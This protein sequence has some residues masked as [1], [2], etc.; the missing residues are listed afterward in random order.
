[1]RLNAAL[2]LTGIGLAAIAPLL[3]G[4]GGDDK[5]PGGTLV[6]LQQDDPDSIDAGQTYGTTGYQIAFATQRPLYSFRP[7]DPT[8]A[9]PD[10][11]TG[12]PR[13][14]A[15]GKTV[16]VHI[17]RGVRFSPPV[18]REVTAADVR[19]AIER[20]FRPTVAN[21]YVSLYFGDLRGLARFQ[22]R[23]G[24][25]ISGIETPDRS[26]LVF[27]LS[28][29]SGR[30]FAGA[31]GLPVTAPVP[32][33]YAAR[34]DRHNP[35][36]YA[37]H[38]V[39]TGPYMIANDRTGKVTGFAPHRRVVL[40]RNPNWDR[41][42]DPRPAPLD[43]IEIRSGVDPGVG[44][45]QIL[46]GH[47][48]VNGDFAPPPAQLRRA[49]E[50]GQVR[51]V[52]EGGIDFVALNTQIAPFDDLNVRKAVLAAFDRTQSRRVSGGALVGPI[53]SHFLP[54][55][56]PGFKEAGGMRGPALD[57]LAAPAG[58]LAVARRYLRKAGYANGRVHSPAVA[59]VGARGGLAQ[60]AAEVAAA[61]LSKLGFH[62][63]LRLV[64]PQA[65]YGLCGAPA[66]RIA[67]CAGHDWI[68]D[69]NDPEVILRPL[70]E[71]A[72]IQPSGNAN[73]SQLRVPRI[74]AAMRR[75]AAIVDPGARARAWGRID[76]MVTAQAPGVP[77]VWDAFPYIWSKDVKPV[78]NLG[79]AGF[80][81]TYTALK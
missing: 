59:L 25:G 27:K 6:V 19:Y 68:K 2:R 30:L 22:K 9:L 53:A 45:R 69:F 64:A 11:A 13:V 72:S 10:L 32:R 50:L 54:P 8:R 67:V 65:V 4:C 7:D 37:G 41:E 70:F 55:A 5:P 52:P 14:A 17:R 34:F 24:A 80:D 21:A 81:F 18:N 23:P 61:Q 31:L 51:A 40:V 38:Q 56:T 43:R 42:L 47:G 33:E 44:A 49:T 16:T 26:T 77:L 71:G 74:D 78:I 20:G 60:A 62:V 28:R 46:V 29:P 76:R 57:F 79:H 48:H 35:S 36:S 1:M 58:D 15:D 66:R 63:D 3:A 39:A 75:A 12:E 73:W